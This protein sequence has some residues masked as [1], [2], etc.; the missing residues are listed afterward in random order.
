MVDYATNWTVNAATRNNAKCN[1]RSA[2]DTAIALF[3][4]PAACFDSGNSS[5]SVNDEL[6]D[7]LLHK[8]IEQT[9]NQ[10][11]R[12]NDQLTPTIQRR[13]AAARFHQN[14]AL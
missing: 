1:I 6:N 5:K 12:K 8:D 4:F 9:R 11:Y 3:S 2:A 10:P 7:Y 14:S 13:T